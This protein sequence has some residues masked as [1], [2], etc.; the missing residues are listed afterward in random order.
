VLFVEEEGSARKLGERL[1]AM[2]FPPEARFELAHLTSMKLDE[3]RQRRALVERLAATQRPVLVLDPMTSLW[4]GD[5]NET[6]AVN[7]LR[8]YLD[9]LATANPAA[10]VVVLHHTSK[11]AA[12]GD[13]H[14]INAARGSSVFSGWADVMLN[15]THAQGPKGSIAL[16]V[17]VVKNR[18]GERGHRANVRIDLATGDVTLD[19]AADPAEDLDERI[20][21][22]MKDAPGGL[23]KRGI[24]SC[25][26]GRTDTVNKR[27]D[28]LVAEG[29]LVKAGEVFKLPEVSP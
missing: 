14:E 27:V 10:L 15:L 20:L 25:V 29:Q 1:E 23:N 19:D 2:R 18:D 4:S 13:G 3:P 6:Q 5:E 8:G 26:R 28:A 21:K 22:A 12:N 11:A 24:K 17:K 7:R 16:D 9:E